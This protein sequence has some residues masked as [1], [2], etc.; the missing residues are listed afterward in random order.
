MIEIASEAVRRGC[1]A[2]TL[3]V[4]SSSEGARELYRQF[5]FV[6]AG[7]RK[8]YYDNVEDAIVMWCHDLATPEYAARLKGLT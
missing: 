1:V 3:E 8:R 7:I 6:P 4:R 2:W 5:G